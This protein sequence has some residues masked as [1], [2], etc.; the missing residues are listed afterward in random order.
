MTA[1][2]LISEGNLAFASQIICCNTDSVTFLIDKDKIQT[3]KTEDLRNAEWEKL[4]DKIR[5]RLGSALYNFKFEHEKTSLVSVY[6]SQSRHVIRLVA[7]KTLKFDILAEFIKAKDKPK[8]FETQ[9]K[10]SDSKT[11]LALEIV[12]GYAF[13]CMHPTRSHDISSLFTD[14]MR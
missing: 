11:K 7:N 13:S 6:P 2:D 5:H 12:G 1:Q 9:L 14:I 10:A 3:F 8:V 4:N